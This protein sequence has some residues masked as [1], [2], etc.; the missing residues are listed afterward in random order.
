MPNKGFLT[1]SS[2]AALMSNGRG[3]DEMGKTALAVVD[4]LVLD[5]IG[6]ERAEQDDSAAPVSCA[7]GKENEWLAIQQYIDLTLSDV[8]IDTFTV[9][10]SHPY[11]GGTMDGK[12]G[13]TGGIEVKCPYSQLEHLANLE[14]GKQIKQYMHQMQ[15]YMFINELDWVDF[16][17]F[18]PLF[19]EVIQ[20][21]IKRVQR[22]NELIEQIVKRCEVAYQMALD[23]VKRLG[24]NLSA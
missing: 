12:V 16:V 20:L 10:R 17:S 9:S 7:W 23:K 15:G 21:F 8:R 2:F 13:R 11:I 24:V 5:M 14:Y 18:S 1:P 22:D 3:S 6:A 19:P 4:Q